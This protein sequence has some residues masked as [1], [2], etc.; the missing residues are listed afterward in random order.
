MVEGTY[1][2]V[3]GA[4]LSEPCHRTEKGSFPS[5]WWALSKDK[6][7]DCKINKSS[8]E[9]LRGLSLPNVKRLPRGERCGEASL[10][11]GKRQDLKQEVRAHGVLPLFPHAETGADW[12]G[13]MGEG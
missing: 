12:Y 10:H 11:Q 2:Q 1:C 3:W 9:V 4:G 13:G 5:G 6:V 8:T 7:L